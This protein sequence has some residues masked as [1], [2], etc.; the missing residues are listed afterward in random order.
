M[1]PDFHEWCKGG[2]GSCNHKKRYKHRVWCDLH[3][4]HQFNR[5]I[6]PKSINNSVG[7]HNSDDGTACTSNF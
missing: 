2:C 7:I 4:R 3:R 6:E 1:K 5:T